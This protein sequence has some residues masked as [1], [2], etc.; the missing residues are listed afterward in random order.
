MSSDIKYTNDLRFRL[1]KHPNAVYIESNEK[2][3]FF[4]RKSNIEQRYKDFYNNIRWN[5][6]FIRNS[7]RSSIGEALKFLI[8]GTEPL[9]NPNL[10]RVYLPK[11]LESELDLFV[12]E[13]A[14]LM[15]FELLED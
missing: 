5:Y 11:T 15:L 14:A 9:I 3:E 8:N 10:S 13:Y 4:I 1:Y 7:E 6:I 12:K 2:S